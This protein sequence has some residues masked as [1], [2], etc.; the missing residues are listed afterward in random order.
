MKSKDVTTTMKLT[1][2]EL[3]TK[4]SLEKLIDIKVATVLIE[5]IQK[6]RQE[7]VY[8]VARRICPGCA[9]RQPRVHVNYVLHDN[10]IVDTEM[11]PGENESA[12]MTECLAA[13]FIRGPQNGEL[14]IN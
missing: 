14:W 8:W 9:A 7:G 2:D 3:R 13:G 5:E 4:E 12:S 10:P 11:H 6:A 1:Y